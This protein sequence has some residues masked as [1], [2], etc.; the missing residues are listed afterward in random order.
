MGY[1]FF[2]VLSDYH[3]LISGFAKAKAELGPLW[4]GMGSGQELC[5][6]ISPAL[7]EQS[8]A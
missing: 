7:F 1:R 3:C 4:D 5:S 2:N 6:R 8:R